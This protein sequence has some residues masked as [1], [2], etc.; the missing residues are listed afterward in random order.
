[1][2]TPSSNNIRSVWP[3]PPLLLLTR[4]IHR[5]VALSRHSIFFLALIPDAVFSLRRWSIHHPILR[6]TLSSTR[7]PGIPRVFQLLHPFSCTKRPAFSIVSRRSIRILTRIRYCR[8]LCQRCN[9]FS[10][11]VFFWCNTFARSWASQLSCQ[12]RYTRDF[13]AVAGGQPLSSTYLGPCTGDGQGRLS[14]IV[15]SH[16]S[17]G[18]SGVSSTSLQY[19]V[20]HGVRTDDRERTF[21]GFQGAKGT[22]R[23]GSS[24]SALMMLV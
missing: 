23:C 12:L 17:V 6:T 9:I 13:L 8:T 5:F 16:P 2:P 21:L 1:M 24:R 4:D 15:S 22:G 20:Y 19:T 7:I 14:C 10:G 11:Q 18:V 3:L